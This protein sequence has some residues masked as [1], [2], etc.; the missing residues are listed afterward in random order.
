MILIFKKIISKNKIKWI[1]LI[2]V[3]DYLMTF[4]GRDVKT[5]SYLTGYWHWKCNF[6]EFK[7]LQETKSEKITLKN[8]V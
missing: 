1:S 8:L 6:A 3:F 5:S 7:I 4:F 2:K